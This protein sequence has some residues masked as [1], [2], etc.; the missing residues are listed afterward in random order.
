MFASNSSVIAVCVLVQYQYNVSPASGI[1]QT[2]VRIA[3]NTIEARKHECKKQDDTFGPS[4]PIIHRTRGL[5]Y[6]SNSLFATCYCAAVVTFCIII[7]IFI[8]KKFS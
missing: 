7:F 3:V 2:L 5:I 4:S 1:I 8:I 6:Y